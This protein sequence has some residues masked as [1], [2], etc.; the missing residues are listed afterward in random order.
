M[1]EEDDVLDQETAEIDPKILAEDDAEVEEVPDLEEEE[2][3]ED[4]EDEEEEDE[5]DDM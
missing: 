3:E 5:E 4:E 1:P 2:A